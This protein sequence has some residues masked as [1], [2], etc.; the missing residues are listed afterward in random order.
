MAGARR[1]PEWKGRKEPDMPDQSP[2]P[3]LLLPEWSATLV[4]R[5]GL[6]LHVRPVSPDDAAAVKQFFAGLAEEDLRF[7]FLTPVRKPGPSLLE[8]LIAVDHVRTEDF[9]AFTD[10]DGTRLLVAS[11]MLAADP[12]TGKAEVAIA[13]RPEFKHR[14]VGWTL[15]D[16]ISAEAKARGVRI[17]ESIECPDNR[18]AI[19]LEREM[20]FT[21]TPHP[22]DASLTLVSKQLAQGE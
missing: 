17:L 20:G 16:F 14:G 4:T 8:T 19:S 9:L 11:A 2:A 5:T 22:G 15:L 12:S 10:V 21:A 18:E 3:T 13:V 1:Q 6:E 7:R